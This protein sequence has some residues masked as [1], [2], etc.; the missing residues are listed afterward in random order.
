MVQCPSLKTYTLCILSLDK[1]SLTS[2]PW[3]VFLDKFY[4]F[5]F[6][7]TFDKFFSW[8][9]LVDLHLIRTTHL[10]VL[11]KFSLLVV[12]TS[13]FPCWKANMTSFWTRLL[14]KENLSSFSHTRANKTLSRMKTVLENLLICMDRALHLCWNWYVCLHELSLPIY[15]EKVSD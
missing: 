12:H 9:V 1:F 7:E 13:K 2:F 3:Q 6:T 15:Y 8:R 5:V 11:D 14:V 10:I 4:L